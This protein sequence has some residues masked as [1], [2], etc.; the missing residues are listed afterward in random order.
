[1][2]RW[3]MVEPAEEANGEQLARRPSRPM[4]HRFVEL[5]GPL[6]ATPDRAELPEFD[7]TIHAKGRPQMLEGQ[8]R[9]RSRRDVQGRRRSFPPASSM[10]MRCSGTPNAEQ[11]PSP[12][13]RS[14]SGRRRS[15]GEGGRDRARARS[16]VTRAGKPRRR[17]R[18][19][20]S[21]LRL[22]ASDGAV[23][24]RAS[25]GRRFPATTGSRSQGSSAQGA[26][27]PVFAGPVK[28]EG[29]GLSTL[30][31][32]AAGDRDMSGQASVGDFALP[33]MPR[34]ATASSNSPTR[35]GELSDTKFS[36]ALSYAAATEA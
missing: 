8:A 17:S 27:G 2:L 4:T 9:A 7:L 21:N 12:A 15:S 11:R 31:R 35:Q 24:D 29:T 10:S 28:L 16:R 26:V 33:P 18:R 1:M 3:S 25:P 20:A 22:A 34:S 32:W 6:K 13:A 5:K 19:R 30:T 14:V 23:D 36:G